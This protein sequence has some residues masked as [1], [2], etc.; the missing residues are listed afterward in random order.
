ML[1][2]SIFRGCLLTLGACILATV[3]AVPQDRRPRARDL[4]A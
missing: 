4:V 2:N 3:T 1:H